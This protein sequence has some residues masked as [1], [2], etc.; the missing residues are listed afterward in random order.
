MT[1]EMV[2]QIYKDGMSPTAFLSQG[3]SKQRFKDHLQ[4]GPPPPTSA[5]ELAFK[6]G[7]QIKADHLMSDKAYL[8]Q[9]SNF[10]DK[11]FYEHKQGKLFGE[12]QR[13]QGK[14]VEELKQQV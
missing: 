8:I 12:K 5:K 13:V 10:D 2:S 9:K 7:V 4:P 14:M 3:N 11:I 6:Y 1:P